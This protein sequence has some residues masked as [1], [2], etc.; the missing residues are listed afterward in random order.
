MRRERIPATSATRR[1]LAS[2]STTCRRQRLPLLAVHD[3]RHVETDEPPQRV[4]EVEDALPPEPARADRR[5]RARGR[6]DLG[7]RGADR[8]RD[9]ERRRAERRADGH[10]D[11]RKR[12]RPQASDRQA[13]GHPGEGRDRERGVPDSEAADE[14]E[15]QQRPAAESAPLDRRERGEQ[16]EAGDERHQ[17]VRRRAGGGHQRHVGCPPRGEERRR[18]AR[19]PAAQSPREQAREHDQQHRAHELVQAVRRVMGQKRDE[20]RQQV[21][22]QRAVVRLVP[23][24]GRELAFQDVPPHQ[25][26]DRVVVGHGQTERRPVQRPAHE[27]EGQGQGQHGQ[28]PPESGCATDQSLQPRS[29]RR[30]NH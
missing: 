13:E 25:Q 22:V 14:A 2:S 8:A 26:Q 7:A 15:A 17:E 24:D 10:D 11:R 16:R 21:G 3:Q 29:A 12:A 6:R 27:H 23:E 28:D 4:R 5:D 1:P 30:R 9:D 19:D 20:R 18:P